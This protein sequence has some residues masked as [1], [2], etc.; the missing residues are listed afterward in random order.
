MHWPVH[1]LYVYWEHISCPDQAAGDLPEEVGSLRLH[2]SQERRSRDRFVTRLRSCSPVL[3][4]RDILEQI[5]ILGSVSLNNGSGYPEADP[6]GP[7]T[8]G[9]GYESHR[10]VT[11]H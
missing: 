4:I 11:K 6:G 2:E 7:K 1:Y 3:R 8:Y 9:S 5:R 10:E